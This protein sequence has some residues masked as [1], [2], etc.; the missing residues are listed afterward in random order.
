MAFCLFNNY[1]NIQGFWK[2][3]LPTPPHNFLTNIETEIFLDKNFNQNLIFTEN[4]MEVECD[5]L[6]W[7][8]Y[9]YLS[10][11]PG[12]ALKNIG[13]KMSLIKFQLTHNFSKKVN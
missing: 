2:F 13:T 8:G 7:Y 9:F 5:V 12:S 6:T 1:I 3:Y 11:P 4:V 10:I